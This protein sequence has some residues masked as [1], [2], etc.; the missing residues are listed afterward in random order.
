MIFS[1]VIF[2]ISILVNKQYYKSGVNL[3][4][5]DLVLMLMATVCGMAVILMFI[6]NLYAFL[7][8]SLIITFANFEILL[9]KYKEHLND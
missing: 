6:S 9:M 5:K 7:I 3:T 2:Y 8:G 1:L 4:K